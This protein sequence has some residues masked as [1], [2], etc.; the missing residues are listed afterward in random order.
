[1]GMWV[2]ASCKIKRKRGACGCVRKSYG[3]MELN[4]S[5]GVSGDNY[6]GQVKR[7]VTGMMGKTGNDTFI[8]K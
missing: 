1:M 8:T 2:A 6:R 4:E 3:I 5:A 7:G